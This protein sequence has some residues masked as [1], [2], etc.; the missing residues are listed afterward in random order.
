LVAYK[1][2]AGRISAPVLCMAQL[3]QDLQQVRISAERLSDILYTAP[4]PAAGPGRTALSHKAN[5]L[6]D[7]C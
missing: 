6:M 1:M 5:K 4:E 2:L 3:W 7:C